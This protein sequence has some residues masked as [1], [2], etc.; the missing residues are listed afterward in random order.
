MPK[1]EKANV[2]WM[3][4]FTDLVSLMLTFFVLLFS[5]SSLQIDKWEEMTDTLSKTLNPSSVKTVAAATA[6]FNISTL[7]RRP[8]TNLDY[9]SG[10]LQAGVKQ[11]PLL[12]KS[13]IMLLEDRLVI[14]LPGDLLFSPGKAVMPEETRSALFTLGGL[15]SNVSNQIAVN[16]HTDPKAP[17]PDAGFTS[18]WELS[19]A[20]ASAVAN[21]LRQAGYTD[22]IFAFGYADSRYQQLPKLNEAERAAMGRRVDII[23][24]PSVGD[25]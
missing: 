2:A 25:N 10:V 1:P 21:S 22:D 19:M 12:A 5:M 23:I 13:Q 16:G 17:G 20:R 15:L 24:L 4:T 14:A 6:E 3:V 18:N 7:I 9:L 11:D 8:A